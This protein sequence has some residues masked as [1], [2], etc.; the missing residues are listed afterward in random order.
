MG[1]ATA[2]WLIGAIAALVDGNPLIALAWFCLAAMGGL[3]ASGWAH[4][5]QA[6]GYLA[7]GLVVVAVAIL[8]FGY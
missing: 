6:A 7:L 1:I 2:L 5:S 3:S 8:F 4:R